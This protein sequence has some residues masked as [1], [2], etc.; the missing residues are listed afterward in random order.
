MCRAAIADVLLRTGLSEVRRSAAPWLAAALRALASRSQPASHR[1]TELG[2][3][4]A[5]HCL[6]AFEL[7]R[8]TDRE[9]SDQDTRR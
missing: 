9:R 8:P 4:A 7:R 3:A 2:Q 1:D 6:K 5:E